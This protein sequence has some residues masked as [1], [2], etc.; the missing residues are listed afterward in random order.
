MWLLAG[1]GLREAEGR[2]KEAKGRL[3]EGRCT[4][5]LPAPKESTRR[6]PEA[7]VV[8]VRRRGLGGKMAHHMSHEFSVP[9]TAQIQ[10]VPLWM[11]ISRPQDLNSRLKTNRHM[12]LCFI[13]GVHGPV[14]WAVPRTNV[15]WT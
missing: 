14:W 8:K 2:A 10:R 4:G 6:R 5:Q 7:H 13:R 15:I 9:E 3:N 11:R 12:T 1:Q